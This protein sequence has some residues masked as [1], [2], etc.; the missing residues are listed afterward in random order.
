MHAVE[1][2]CGMCMP[3]ASNDSAQKLTSIAKTQ[4]GRVTI[5]H[6]LCVHIDKSIVHPVP[7]KIGAPV[8]VLLVPAL[9]TS[10]LRL[11]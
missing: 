8:H 6:F 1:I 11:D 10:C 3:P 9:T 2:T 5:A 7:H 4:R